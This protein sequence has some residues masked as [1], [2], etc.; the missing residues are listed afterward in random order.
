MAISTLW[1]RLGHLLKG[2]QVTNKEGSIPTKISV[3]LKTMPLYPVAQFAIRKWKIHQVSQVY[4][5]L[6]TGERAPS[7]MLLLVFKTNKKKL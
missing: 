6:V 3:A 5:Y 1:G 4:L 7:E 2:M